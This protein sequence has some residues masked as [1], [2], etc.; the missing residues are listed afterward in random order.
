MRGPS[1]VMGGRRP[2]EELSR[3]RPGCWLRLG[4]G[5]P[6]QPYSVRVGEGDERVAVAGEHERRA[7]V[8]GAAALARRRVLRW[9]AIPLALRGR[10]P[11][12]PRP[13]ARPRPPP[14]Q[15]T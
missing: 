12:P 7:L 4:C 14:S 13:P 6:L 10:E 15:R 3:D 2:V 5:E 11:R 8:W 9:T 1:L